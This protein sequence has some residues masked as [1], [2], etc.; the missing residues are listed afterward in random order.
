MQGASERKN[1]IPRT[2]VLDGHLKV[3]RVDFSDFSTGF[4]A[5][6]AWRLVFPHIE[7]EQL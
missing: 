5:E 3:R 2:L 4:S 6:C 7:Y 1:G